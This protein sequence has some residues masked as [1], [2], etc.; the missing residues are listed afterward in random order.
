MKQ[1]NLL[2]IKPIDQTGSWSNSGITSSG[3]FANKNKKGLG[4]EIT[5]FFMFKN[6]TYLSI[7]FEIS[8]FKA[9]Y[10]ELLNVV[11][12]NNTS[13]QNLLSKPLPVADL[14][15]H[16]SKTYAVACRHTES[17]SPPITV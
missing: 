6:R 8:A 12:N 3:A 13:T 4:H 2:D 1:G 10:E 14:K 11:S 9:A 5:A 17:I 16:L 15:Q 7:T